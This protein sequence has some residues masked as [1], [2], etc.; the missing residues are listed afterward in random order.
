ML[1]IFETRHKQ[2]QG[3]NMWGPGLSQRLAPTSVSQTRLTLHDA[4]EVDRNPATEEV[5]RVRP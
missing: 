5:Q 1:L 2:K 4:D 3:I